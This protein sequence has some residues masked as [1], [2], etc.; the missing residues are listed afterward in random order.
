MAGEADTEAAEG[1]VGEVGKVDGD[2]VSDGE[3]E[4]GEASSVPIAAVA[5][6]VSAIRTSQHSNS[7]DDVDERKRW[8]KKDSHTLSG[9]NACSRAA[10]RAAVSESRLVPMFER[11]E[12]E[13]CSGQEAI[14]PRRQTNTQPITCAA[15]GG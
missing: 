10:P 9:S 15:A 12:R 13:E 8:S 5:V 3:G 2:W 14:H 1:E 4:E 11:L 7:A 6:S